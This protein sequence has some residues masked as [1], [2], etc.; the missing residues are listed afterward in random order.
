VPPQQRSPD[1]PHET[2]VCVASHVVL[3]ALQVEPGQHV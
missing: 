2:Q 1:V 3:A